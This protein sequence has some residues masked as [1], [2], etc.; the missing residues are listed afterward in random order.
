MTDISPPPPLPDRVET[1]AL[2]ALDDAALEAVSAEIA[3]TERA[4]IA[5]MAPY[6]RQL[7]ELRA[8]SAEIATE[9]RRRERQAHIAKRAA[10]R[11]AAK[12]GEMPTVR[13]VL[14]GAPVDETAPLADCPAFL[15]TGG[16]VRFGYATRPGPLAFTDGRQSRNAT[17]WGEARELYAAGWEPGSPGVPGVR[18]HMAGSRVER[19]VGA[20]EVV[21]GAPG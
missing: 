13:E 10:V 8:R 17:T 14:E 18:V 12:A 20:D 15:R 5:A 21:V 3:A 1:E 11:E 16:E 9:R 6:D 2:Q 19:V 7:R 4:T